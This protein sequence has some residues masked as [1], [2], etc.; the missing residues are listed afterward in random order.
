MVL[1]EPQLSVVELRAFLLQ[2]EGTCLHPF[3]S[4][5]ETATL[6]ALTP[7]LIRSASVALVR[8]EQVSL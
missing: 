4:E 3:T 1:C 2:F 5:K 6:V 7:L 8:I